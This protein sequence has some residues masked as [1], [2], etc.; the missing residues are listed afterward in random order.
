MPTRVASF[1]ISC[2][3]HL[4]ASGS[5][6]GE[7]PQFARDRKTLVELYTAMVKTRHFDTKAIALNA[8]ADWGP[9]LQVL[10]RKP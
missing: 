5:P 8:P 4:D 1:E 10:A 9:M 2:T 6:I 3:A 7:L